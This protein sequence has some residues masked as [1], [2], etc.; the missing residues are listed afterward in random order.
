MKIT[1]KEK[2]FLKYITNDIIKNYQKYYCRSNYYAKIKI[3]TKLG[4]GFP[5]QN[6]PLFKT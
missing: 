2:K 5:K 1:F 6:Y 3:C 4:I